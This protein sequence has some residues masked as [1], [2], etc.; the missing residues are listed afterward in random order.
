MFFIL[1]TKLWKVDV[2]ES[3]SF[4]V[5]SNSFVAPWTIAC[6]SSGISRRSSPGDI[7]SGVPD[8]TWVSHVA[9]RFFTV[10]ATREAPVCSLKAED[11]IKLFLLC[12]SLLSWMNEWSRS[13]LSDSLHPHGLQSY[14]APAS[15]G[16][17][18]ARI[19]EWVAI[20]FSR[21]SFQSR[22][23]TSVSCIAGR[24]FAVW[25]TREDLYHS[26]WRM[27]HAENDSHSS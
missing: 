11:N 2:S 17:F 23:R 14:Q 16:F 20:S 21:G 8:Q 6:Q 25:A 3:V 10:W 4:S 27:V 12:P 22:D 9:G 24:W 7:W 26:L 13:V 18:Q 1:L 19:L 5:L 15:M